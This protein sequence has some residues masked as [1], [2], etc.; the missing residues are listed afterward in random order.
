MSSPARDGGIRARG[1]VLVQRAV[2]VASGR[3]YEA[4][5]QEL[6][7][8]PLG[9]ESSTFLWRDEISIRLARP[10]TAPDD[11]MAHFADYGERRARALFHWARDQGRDPAEI[12]YE[13]AIAS[14]RD[15]RDRVEAETGRP[16]PDVAPLPIV[17]TPNAAGSL[18]DRAGLP[19]PAPCV[20]PARRST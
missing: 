5:A 7:F 15:V 13:D 19:A 4:L 8:E 6:V 10:T 9:M 17:L 11:R 1:Y 12:R 2:E 14:D 18:N 20:A 16:L 3:G